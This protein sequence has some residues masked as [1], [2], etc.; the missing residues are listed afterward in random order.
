MIAW[1]EARA[2][3]VGT[4]AASTVALALAGA[5]VVEKISHARTEKERAGLYNQIYTPFTGYL[6]RNTQLTSN[7]AT[8]SGSLDRQSAAIDQL[9]DDSAKRIAEAEKNLVVA[10]AATAAAERRIGVLLQPLVAADTC[11]RVVEMDKRLLE[12]LK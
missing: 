11:R 2:W 10:R 1:L 12:T 4:I 8:C 5:L 9:A 7:L 3:Q 6:A